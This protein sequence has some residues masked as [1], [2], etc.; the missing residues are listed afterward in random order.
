MTGAADQTDSFIRLCFQGATT[1]LPNFSQETGVS[2]R[3]RA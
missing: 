1:A 3:L 2:H